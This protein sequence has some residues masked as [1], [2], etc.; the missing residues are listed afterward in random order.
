MHRQ[1]PL[2]RLVPSRTVAQPESELAI[3]ISEDSGDVD[4]G[5]NAALDPLHELVVLSQPLS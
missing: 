5:I 4:Q 3:L 1:P 2:K